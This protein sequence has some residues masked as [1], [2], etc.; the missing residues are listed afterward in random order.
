MNAIELLTQDHKNMRALLDELT[1]TTT[2]GVKKRK[3]LLEKIQTNLTVHNTIEEEIFYPAFK[4]AGDGRDDAKMYFEAL[5][6]HRAAGDLVL[7]D[8]LKTDAA[9]EKFSGRAKVLKEL[10]EHH[11]DEEEKEMFKRARALMGKKA[12]DELGEQLA[13]RKLELKKKAQAG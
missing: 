11:A 13:Q 3:E 6:E 10:F 1:G 2:R 7:P 12:I 9:S 5:E 8:L 4:D